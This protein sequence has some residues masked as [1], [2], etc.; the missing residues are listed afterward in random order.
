MRKLR[1][2]LESCVG[3]GHHADIRINRAE[4]IIFRR[5]FV[6]SGDGIKKRRFPYVRQSDN[7]CAEH[8]VRTL[9]RAEKNRNFGA[10]RKTGLPACAPSG[11]AVRWAHRLKVCV[12]GQSRISGQRDLNPRPVAAATVLQIQ[13]GKFVAASPRLEI[14]LSSHG[15]GPSRETFLFHE[16]PWDSVAHRLAMTVLMPT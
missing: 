11:H 8:E 14:A 12:P 6:R 7:S 5:R 4:W 1:E 16:K 3:H 13:H 2:D 10:C 15:F 9:P